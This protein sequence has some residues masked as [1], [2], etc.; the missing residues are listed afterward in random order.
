[1]VQYIKR[2]QSEGVAMPSLP[3]GH[4]HQHLRSLIFY[5]YS[6]HAFICTCVILHF[7]LYTLYF[8]APPSPQVYPSTKSIN[9]YIN[10][11]YTACT[12]VCQHTHCAILHITAQMMAGWVYAHL[13]LI[14]NHWQGVAG[15]RWA[16]SN[17]QR[18]HLGSWWLVKPQIRLS[19]NLSTLYSRDCPWQTQFGLKI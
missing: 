4:H 13:Q 10:S 2:R 15:G 17:W 7:I 1:M 12:L 14:K 6:I 11:K 16:F 3:E 5:I 9:T 19:Q 8:T 18:H